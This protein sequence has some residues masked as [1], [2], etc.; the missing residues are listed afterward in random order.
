MINRTLRYSKVS[1]DPPPHFPLCIVLVPGLGR[2]RVQW[3]TRP[4][5]RS[6]RFYPSATSKHLLP[7]VSAPT[8]S[9]SLARSLTAAAMFVSL[10]AAAVAEGRPAGTRRRVRRQESNAAPASSQ[11]PAAS[12]R[13]TTV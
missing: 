9:R 7:L 10:R 4:A 13:M 2:G 1:P 12:Q 8:A 3:R 6:L 11:Q 5:S